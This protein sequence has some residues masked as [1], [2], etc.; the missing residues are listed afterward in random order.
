MVLGMIIAVIVI[1]TITTITIVLIEFYVLAIRLS[2][3]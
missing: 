3:P 2:R 1:L